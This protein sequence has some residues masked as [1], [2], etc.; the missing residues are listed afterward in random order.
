MPSTFKDHFSKQSKGY[1]DFRPH[2]PSEWF[3][4]LAK[5][6]PEKALAV[7]VAT[8]SGQ[9]AV[10]LAPHFATVRA[11]DASESQVKNARPLD[12]IQYEV[13]QAELIPVPDHTADLVT[14]AQ[15]VHWFDRPLF[16]R[17]VKRIT[18]PQG[19]IAMWAYGLAEI[20]P[21]VDTLVNH[22]YRDIVGSFWP[23]ERAWIEKGYAALDFPFTAVP[24][25]DFYMRADWTLDSLIGYLNTW[26]ATQRAREVWQREPLQAIEAELV[27]AFGPDPRPVRWKMDIRVGKT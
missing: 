15:A 21:K 4:W 11:F 8:G 9:A 13:A 19:L 1:R 20:D 22:Y 16:Y 3:E 26:S 5:Q 14:V 27:E 23:P 17:E 2:Y 24:T 7:D 10:G 25:P 12:N 18:R 6:C